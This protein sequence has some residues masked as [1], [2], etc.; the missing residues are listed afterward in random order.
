MGLAASCLGSCLASCACSACS[1]AVSSCCGSGKKGSYLP[2]LLILFFSTALALVLYLWG[3]PLIVHLTVKDLILCDSDA[4][5]GFGAVARISFS[6]FLFFLGHSILLL[7][8]SCRQLDSA[9]W[10]LRALVLFVILVG[11]WFIPSQFYDVYTQVSRVVSGIFLVIQV[12]ILIDF[13]YSW[14][15]VQHTTLTLTLTLTLNNELKWEL[16]CTESVWIG[17]V[18]IESNRIVSFAPLFFF[19]PLIDRN[20]QPTS[21]RQ[22]PSPNLPQ[23]PTSNDSTI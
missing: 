5:Y 7:A 11:A 13:A 15:E 19:F 4:C 8:S 10:G 18:G 22:P 20:R 1:S 9:S 2:Y 17:S 6:L 14:N 16:D 21:N 23:L 12:I 3:Q